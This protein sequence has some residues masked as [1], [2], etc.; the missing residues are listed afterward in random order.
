[1][2]GVRCMIRCHHCLFLYKL[3]HLYSWFFFGNC[4]RNHYNIMDLGQKLSYFLK[5]LLSRSVFVKEHLNL[6]MK[7][8]ALGNINIRWFHIFPSQ[9]LCSWTFLNVLCSACWASLCFT[10]V[11]L[12]GIF[13]C[14][15]CLMKSHLG[16]CMCSASHSLQWLWRNHYVQLEGMMLL[17][18]WAPP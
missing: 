17:P 11:W 14:S 2:S 3:C 7:V 16:L 9:T 12:M 13:K 4:F 8:T 15:Y 6:R 18:S 5:I 1:M 10:W